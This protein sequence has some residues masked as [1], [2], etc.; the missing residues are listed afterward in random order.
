M[1]RTAARERDDSHRRPS[2]CSTSPVE[3]H[4]LR[5]SAVNHPVEPQRPPR[6]SPGRPPTCAGSQRCP[7]TRKPISSP[8]RPSLRDGRNAEGRSKVSH[9][10][11]HRHSATITVTARA[12]NPAIPP[13]RRAR[14]ADAAKSWSCALP[15]ARSSWARRVSLRTSGPAGGSVRR[16][17]ACVMLS[18]SVAA[19]VRR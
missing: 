13:V 10:P 18:G 14:A 6:P 1:H 12:A 19:R 3:A 9:P 8:W 7:R 2:R 4:R 15:P 17:T 16:T 11:R 5:Y